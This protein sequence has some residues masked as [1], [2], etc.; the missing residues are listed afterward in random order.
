MLILS[1]LVVSSFATLDTIGSNVLMNVS[2]VEKQNEVGVSDNVV[3]TKVGTE[4]VILEDNVKEI[5]TGESFTS[6]KT[7]KLVTKVYHEAEIKDKEQKA[8]HNR[9][10]LVRRYSKLSEEDKSQVK[11]ELREKFKQRKKEFMS[12][13]EVRGNRLKEVVKSN[14]A[15]LR[16]AIASLEDLENITGLGQNISILVKE[17]N[18]D[19]K[20]TVVEEG[21]IQNRSRIKSFFVGGNKE[22]AEKIKNQISRNEERLSKMNEDLSTIE[23]EELKQIIS[24][25]IGILKT[26]QKRLENL[27]EKEIN[28]KGLFGWIW[29]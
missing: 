13:K 12:T 16:A 8:T 20:K 1:S 18:S 7:R 4:R 17:Y 27:S 14:R 19:L 2:V 21:L 11:N 22:A 6:N 10:R 26:E 9:T 23:D 28:K 24:E 15:E 3:K 5:E 25:Q 29:K